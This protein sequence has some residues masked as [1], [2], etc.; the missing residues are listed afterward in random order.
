MRVLGWVQRDAGTVKPGGR[1]AVETS[2]G[3]SGRPIVVVM[4]LL[5]RD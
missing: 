2:S 3:D 5:L 4:F 1:S